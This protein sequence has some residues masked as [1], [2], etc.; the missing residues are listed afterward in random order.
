MSCY[1]YTF[2]CASCQLL[3]FFDTLD[4]TDFTINF[5]AID[6]NKFFITKNSAS[7]SNPNMIRNIHML[8]QQVIVNQFALSANFFNDVNALWIWFVFNW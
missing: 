2:L 7:L 6:S 5:Q 1:N 4:L 3:S 8:H